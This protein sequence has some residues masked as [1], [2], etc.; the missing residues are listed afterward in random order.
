MKKLDERTIIIRKTLIR[1]G[2]R[3]DILGFNYLAA[4]VEIAIDNPKALQQ[5]KYLLEII[6]EKF[7]EKNKSKVEASMQHA[8]VSTYDTR[9]FNSINE[10][11]GLDLIRPDHKPTICELVKILV[12]YYVLEIYKKTK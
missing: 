10:I 11:F 12:N 1:I 7:H 6:C 5:L 3:C 2:I 9:G 8:I 4:A